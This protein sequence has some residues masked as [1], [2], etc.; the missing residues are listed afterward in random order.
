MNFL[1][2]KFFLFFIIVTIGH[3]QTSIL[4]I[5]PITIEYKKIDTISLKLHVYYPIDFDT[6]KV[7]NTIIFFHGGGWNNGNYTAFS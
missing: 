4:K 2:T 3:C 5:N 1:K 6:T 7:Y